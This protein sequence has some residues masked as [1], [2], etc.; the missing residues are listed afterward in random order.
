[1]SKDKIAFA[2]AAHPDD[3]EFM[4]AGTLALLGRAGYELHYM[5][6]A[7]GSCGSVTMN[8]ERTIATR[9]REAQEAAAMLGAT[10]HPPLADDIQIYYEPRLV[11]R[12][13]AIV[14]EVRP[15]VL[16]LP[17]PLDYMEDHTNTSRLMVTAAFC[18]NMPN[19]PTDPPRPAIDTQMAVYHALP[20]GLRDQLRRPVTA[21][22]HVDVTS[23][24]DIKRRALTCHKSQK[25]WLDASQGL[26]SYIKT[27]ED[28]CA[29]VGLQS[30]RFRFAEGWSRHSHLGFGAE[31]F[32]P[33]REAIGESA[34]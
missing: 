18:R 17:S 31:E 14:R 20:Y 23:V 27:M 29:Q 34:A 19:F 9:T 24:M 33:L 3:I 10:F 4:M 8:R 13:C 12:L 26:D 6:I 21:E 5:N 7:N 15:R 2:V 25:E 1:M 11:A 30:G 28:L 32:D 16:L 22:F